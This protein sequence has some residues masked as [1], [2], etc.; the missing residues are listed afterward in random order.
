MQ[1]R[2]PFQRGVFRCAHPLCTVPGGYEY[3]HRWTVIRHIKGHTGEDAVQCQFCDLRVREKYL[4]G[5]VR[6][7][8][9]NAQ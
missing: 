5:H 1:L 9:P 4:K 3:G 2:S 6:T 7:A 8:H